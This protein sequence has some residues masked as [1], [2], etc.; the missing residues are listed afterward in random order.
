MSWRDSLKENKEG[1]K[2]SKMKSWVGG[3][4]ASRAKALLFS[5]LGPGPESLSGKYGQLLITPYNTNGGKWVQI[6][7]PK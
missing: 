3:V 2:H 1:Y 6:S 4:M 7:Q 5:S